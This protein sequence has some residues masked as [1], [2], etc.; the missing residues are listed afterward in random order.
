MNQPDRDDDMR[1]ALVGMQYPCDRRALLHHA[2]A[3]GAD[4]RLL[5]RLGTLPD[6]DFEEL[7]AVHDALIVDRDE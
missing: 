4:D 3:H 5:G 2:A 6:G 7:A 1:A